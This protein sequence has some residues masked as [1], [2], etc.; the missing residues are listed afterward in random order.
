M[1]SRRTYDVNDRVR[2]LRL[3]QRLLL[4]DMRR[5]NLSLRRAARRGGVPLGTLYL[6]LD[7]ARV[8]DPNKQPKRCLRKSTLLLLKAMPWLGPMASTT[9]GRLIDADE[10]HTIH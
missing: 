9:L 7:P 8:S 3:V 1:T 10:Q 2:V 6:V 4:R 5:Q